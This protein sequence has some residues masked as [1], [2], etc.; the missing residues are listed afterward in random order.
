M[1]LEV[2][3]ERLRS[4]IGTEVHAGEW[5]VIDQARIDAFAAATGD[6][7]WIHV[8]R[9]RALRDSPWHSTI[10]HG[11]LTLSLVP[12]LRRAPGIAESVPF[13]DVRTTINYGVNRVRFMN[14]VREGARIRGRSSLLSVEELPGALE[15]IE[16]FTV[17]IE[18]EKKPACVAEIVLRLY[19]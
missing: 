12:M 3:R 13:T 2:T 6:H 18:G 10:A 1:T 19:P 16:R 17:E 8:D 4:R 14:P 9:E 11:F 5:L 7:Q 15:L